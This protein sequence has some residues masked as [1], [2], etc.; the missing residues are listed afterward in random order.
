MVKYRFFLY[1]LAILNIDRLLPYYRSLNNLFVL[2]IITALAWMVTI[3]ENIYKFLNIC[4]TDTSTPIVVKRSTWRPLYYLLMTT[5]RFWVIPIPPKLNGWEKSTIQPSPQ[6]LNLLPYYDPMIIMSSSCS[7][8][9]ALWPP[10][11][12]YS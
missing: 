7:A 12:W 3:F 4:F 6:I 9:L 2:F 1:P 5:L 10:K 11:T 8:D